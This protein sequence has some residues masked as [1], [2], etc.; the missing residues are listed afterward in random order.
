MAQLTGGEAIV[1][2]LAA[3]GVNTLFGLP[4]I[5]SDW[6]YNALYDAGEGVIRVIHTRHEQG[7]GYMALGYALARGDVGVFNVVPGPGMLNAS[8]ALATAYGL[9]AQVLCLSGQLPTRQ[10]GKGIGVLHE[11]PDQ[12]G[13]LQ[14]LTKWAARVNSPAEAPTLIG[15]AMRQMRSGQ[16]RPVALEAPMDVL[17][18]R[19]EV[20]NPHVSFP[21]YYPPLDSEQLD[22][23]AL[24]LGEAREPLIYVGSG[25]QGV[26]DEVRK[27]AEDLQAPVVAYRTGHGVLDGRHPLSLPIYPSHHLWKTADVVLA[28]GSNL[29]IPLSWGVD[30]ALKIIRIDVDPVAHGR[31]R[32]PD[33]AITARAEEALPQLITGVAK[34]NRQRP[35]RE[36]ELRALK[37]DWA[38]QIAYLEPQLSFL[39]VIREELGEDGI[40]VDELTQVGFVSRIAWPAYKPR[41]Y[42]STGYQGTLGYGFPTALGVKVARPDV[43]V[44]SIA[45]DGGFMFTVQ[46]LSTAVQHHIG[47]VVLV[48][49][50]DQYGNVQQMQKHDYGGRVIATDLRNPDF[51][52]LAESFGAQ[53]FRADN[54]DALRQAVRHGFA[55]HQVPTLIEVPIGD[56]PTTDRFRALPRVR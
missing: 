48:F 1:Q 17:A 10:I 42:I 2:A 35:S 19:G 56:V 26:S 8:A 37:A 34:H 11:I 13:I 20:A 33:L 6:L 44:I 3:H 51:V 14:R 15:E 41:T 49:N 31:I 16:P 54:L 29:R 50:N 55:N 27:L 36:A 18:Q 4:G 52:K 23:A 45:G 30:D 24:L 22:K 38:A 28:I 53:A 40:F 39:K 47:V 43:P 32:M 21:E 25:A 7:A 46:E 12:L 5:Q 9:G